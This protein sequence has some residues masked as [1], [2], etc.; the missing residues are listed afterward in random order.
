MPPTAPTPSGSDI[1]SISG[2]TAS[3]S[4][5]VTV[6]DDVTNCSG[7]GCS[8]TVTT[9]RTR[10]CRIN[11]TSTSGTIVT[12]VGPADT[13]PD[14]GDPFRHAPD[15]V[16]F[17][18]DGVTAN[19]VF[20]VTFD[21]ASAAGEW[22]VPFEVCYPVRDSLHGLLRQHG[23]DDR[24]PAAVR[25]P[26]RGPLRGVDHGVARPSGQSRPTPAMS[27]RRSWYH[28]ATPPSSTRCQRAQ[29]GR[30]RS[31]SSFRVNGDSPD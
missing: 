19:I 1:D 11:S 28:R 13:A 31:P 18:T 8:G 5:P 15:V 22:Y 30:T 14:C 6:G 29:V 21:N 7:S 3:T 26:R 24:S 16:T 17:D 27:S 9:A 20:T 4:E 12:T 25:E 10:R 2:S 23:R